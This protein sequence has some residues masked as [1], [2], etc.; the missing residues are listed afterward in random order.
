MA[1]KHSCVITYIH[2]EEFHFPIW[3]KYYSQHFDKK[4]IYVLFHNDT[5]NY[6][7]DYSCFNKFTLKTEFDHDFESIHS[8][9]KTIIIELLKEYSG[10]YLAESDEIIW[11][12]SGLSNRSQYYSYLPF[13]VIRC[14][15]YEVPHQYWSGESPIDVNKPLLEQRSI[16]KENIWQRKPAYFKTQIDYWTN[17]H[18]FDEK[19]TFID[20][21]LTL[22]HLKTIDYQTMWDRNQKSIDNLKINQYTK[23]NYIGWQ[24]RIESR[25]QFDTFFKTHLEGCVV[26]PEKYK[27]II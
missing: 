23:D 27:N 11:H 26:I 15:A 8:H 17:M 1:K 25:E 20:A 9:L 19:Y 13:Q 7:V 5:A 4:D 18:N 2:N 10:I 6:D 21:S 24:N 22:V 16:W 3:L 12:P 14:M